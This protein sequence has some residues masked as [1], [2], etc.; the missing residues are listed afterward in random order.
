ML[1]LRDLGLPGSNRQARKACTLLL[2]GGLQ[3][4]GGIA[5]GT[6]AHWTRRGETCITGMVR[7]R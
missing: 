7:R 5:Y 3:P 1:T 4:D 2:D 6:W